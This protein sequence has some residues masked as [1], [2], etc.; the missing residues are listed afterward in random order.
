VAVRVALALVLFSAAACRCER[1]PSGDGE[2]AADAD[3]SAELA[4]LFE[5]LAAATRRGDGAR[6]R[7]LA[8]TTRLEQPR[9]WFV[10]V[11]GDELGA[12][13]AAEFVSYDDSHAKL[14]GLVARVLASDESR[15]VVHRVAAADAPG[16]S[17]AQKQA[18]AAMRD[19]VPLYT[20][21]L[22]APG[23]QHGYRLESFVYERGGFRFVGRLGPVTP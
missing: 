8:A 7:E 13:L 17:E 9:A 1:A 22:V 15:V 14:P 6:A 20:A 2:G 16:A 12:R 4:L 10:R 5:E 18:L 3:R 11:F 19:P 23:S 21:E